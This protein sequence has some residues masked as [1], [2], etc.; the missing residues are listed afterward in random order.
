M[1]V[2]EATEK[3]ENI[4]KNAHDTKLVGHQRVLKTEKNTRKNDL[5]K[6]Q[7]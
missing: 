4:I 3:N 6:H 2:A 7:N 1:H 5:E